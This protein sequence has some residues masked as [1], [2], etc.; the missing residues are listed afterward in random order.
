MIEA[1]E[2]ADIGDRICLHNNIP[3]LL[4]F[5]MTALSYILTIQRQAYLGY[6]YLHLRFFWVLLKHSMYIAY[7]GILSP[8]SL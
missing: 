6:V 5:D 3:L 1:G 2:A 8:G 7:L 4:W